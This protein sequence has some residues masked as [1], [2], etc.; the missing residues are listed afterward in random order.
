MK[1]YTVWIEIEEFD[2]DTEGHTKDREPI[3][4]ARFDRK[5]NAMRFAEQLKNIG[6]VTAPKFFG[7]ASP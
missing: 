1:S 3:K 6:Q 2:D 5:V 7:E 4:I